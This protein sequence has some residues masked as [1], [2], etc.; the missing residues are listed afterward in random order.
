[1]STDLMERS[2]TKSCRASGTP[3]ADTPAPAG[4]PGIGVERVEREQHVVDVGDGIEVTRY[5]ISDL[6][7]RHAVESEGRAIADITSKSLGVLLA[8]R[9]I[10]SMMMPLGAQ[11]IGEPPGR[12]IDSAAR[13]VAVPDTARA[14]EG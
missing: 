5:R 14:V 6:P 7:A 11:L 13:L 4:G 12:Q 2:S 3:A 8:P 10:P 1:M 9:P